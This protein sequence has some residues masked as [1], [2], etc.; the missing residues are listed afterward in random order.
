MA[1]FGPN[2]ESS[3]ISDGIIILNNV[4]NVLKKMRKGP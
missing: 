4:T 1:S 3:I 2:E